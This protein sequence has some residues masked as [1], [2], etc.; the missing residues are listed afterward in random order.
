MAV[1]FGA[2]EEVRQRMA[3]RRKRMRVPAQDKTEEQGN[4][5]TQPDTE[6]ETSS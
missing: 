4:E 3:E 2:K 5:A 1:E 6:T